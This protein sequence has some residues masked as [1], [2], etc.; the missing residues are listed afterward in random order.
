[1]SE[2]T[3]AKLLVKTLR[4][5]GVQHVFGVPSGGWVDYLEA[6]RQTD[7]ISFVLTSHEGGAAFMADVCGQLTGVPGVCFGTFGPGATNLSTGV[8]CALLDRSPMI[9]FTDEL[10]ASMRGRTTQMGIDHQALFRPLTK[11]T[12]RLEPG[13]VQE[14]LFDATRT[15]L[16][17]RPGPVHIGLPVDISAQSAP[18]NGSPRPQP[19]APPM[20][21]EEVLLKAAEL[22]RRSRKPVLVIGLGAVRAGVRNEV[23]TLAEGV[24]A[25]IV[26]TPMAKGMVPED[27]PCYAGV[28]F[29]ALSD[30]V[31]QTHQQADLII[32][33]GYDPVEFNYE[34]WLPAVPVLSIDTV[35]ADLDQS[36]YELA[37]EIVGDIRRAVQALTRICLLYTSPSPR[38]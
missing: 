13:R 38:D 14:I 27:H 17:E 20:P 5:I 24:G 35:P 10:P 28:F 36:R 11:K 2:E 12:T 9:A 18:V 33:I 4:E 23:L 29:H 3:V 31:A 30:Q 15:A 19:E 34:S 6:I 26:L 8:G 21:S 7:G 1:M 37:C 32:A 16:S 22:L 25:P